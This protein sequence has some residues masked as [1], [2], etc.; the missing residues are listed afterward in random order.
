MGK[1]G[2]WVKGKAHT[3]ESFPGYKCMSSKRALLN[4]A[5]EH[6]STAE[7]SS[8]RKSSDVVRMKGTHGVTK[9]QS[10]HPNN[11]DH[12]FRK[13]K[14]HNTLTKETGGMKPWKNKG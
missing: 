13:C 6:K 10:D 2:S 9:G 7:S 8:G 11:K 1:H 5:H 14:P 3:P 12:E 4:K